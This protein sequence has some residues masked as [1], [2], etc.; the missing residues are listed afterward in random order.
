MKVNIS[1]FL[2]RSARK[3]PTTEAL[4]YRD[5]RITYE[6]LSKLVDRLSSSL[7]RLGLQVG[8]KVATLFPNSPELVITYF[9]ILKA[10][11]VLVPLTERLYPDDFVHMINHS[12]AKFLI[13]SEHFVETIGCI[14]D[15]FP[16]VGYF[17]CSDKELLDDYISFQDLIAQELRDELEIDLSED[18]EF[19]ILYTAGTTGRSKG[20][21]L[22]HRNVIWGTLN[23]A[24]LY[25]LYPEKV[26][27]TFPLSHKAGLIG[28]FTRIMRGDTVVL[29]DSD[30]LELILETVQKE[31]ITVLDII[32]SLSNALSQSPF[33]NKY[34]RT[35]V[36][37]VGSSADF[38]PMET[39]NRMKYLFPNAGI[40]DTY[41]MTEYSGPI[42][43]LSPK[44]SMRK[45]SCIGKALPHSDVRVVRIQGDD[46]G[47]EEVG[48]I[49]VR[50]PQVMQCYYKDEEKSKQ[51][52]RD[53][54][55]FTGDLA[56]VDKDGFLYIVGR[57]DP[58]V[59]TEESRIFPKEIEG[60]LI[61]PS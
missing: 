35:S 5:Q 49:V 55:L 27:T 25:A 6:E 16:R 59:L 34:D 42:C 50:G 8:D 56:K 33:A 9:A 21:L 30:D 12:E 10:G 51:A 58:Q 45:E 57:K 46:V 4:V 41:G 11:G 3:F 38:L 18:S 26:L 43:S 17:I 19:S 44:D 52:I 40:S 61:F 54:W 1:Y 23:Q 22:T 14:R 7:R 29:I 31:L 48:E 20:A 15:R 37:L 36:K 53:Q 2:T 28:V 32:P 13:F 60:L 24:S 39:K 47:T